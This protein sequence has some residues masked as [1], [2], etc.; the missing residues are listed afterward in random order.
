MITA[1]TAVMEVSQAQKLDARA[2]CPPYRVLCDKLDD[3]AEHN[4][5][6]PEDCDVTRA[7]MIPLAVEAITVYDSI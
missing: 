5:V 4:Q 7:K 3:L 2:K 6:H 1:H